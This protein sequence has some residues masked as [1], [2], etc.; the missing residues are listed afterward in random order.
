M[1]ARLLCPAALK[2]PTFFFYPLQRQRLGSGGTA[3]VHRCQL[4]GTHMH[5]LSDFLE[6]GEA[7]VGNMLCPSCHHFFVTLGC[8]KG[9]HKHTL[10]RIKRKEGATGQGIAFGAAPAER[11]H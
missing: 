4:L 9:Y 1:I 7:V 5:T 8:L 2:T 11:N 10:E 3:A 6:N